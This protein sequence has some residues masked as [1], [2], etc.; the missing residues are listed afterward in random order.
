MRP[1]PQFLHRLKWDK[2]INL[3]KMM[4]DFNWVFINWRA[5]TRLKLFFKKDFII[6]SWDIQREERQRHRQREKQAPHREPDVGLDP[7]TRGSHPEP[8]ADTQLLS[9][10]G[11]PRLKLLKWV[12]RHWWPPN[13]KEIS[14]SR[15]GRKLQ[16]PSSEI[17]DWTGLQEL[18]SWHWESPKLPLI[19]NPPAPGPCPW[20]GPI[21][22]KTF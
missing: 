15:R 2:D 4:L 13:L 22:R 8:K 18:R 12:R 1:K 17:L 9:L 7:R 16:P 21:G 20:E 5:Q 6:Y 3:S 19:P 11:I 14:F 10:P